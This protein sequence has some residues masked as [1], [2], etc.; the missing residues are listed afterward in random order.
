M[1]LDRDQ[2]ALRFNREMFLLRFAR[3]VK[4]AGED[5]ESVAGFF[6]FAAVRVE[7]P[8][9]EVRFFGRDECKDSITTKSPI[10]IADKCDVF[11]C[12]LERE[13]LRF[14]DNVVVAQAM[15]AEKT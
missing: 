2:A 11:R 9:T 15:A 5:A 6:R 3:R 10:A 8:Q 4:I 14:H 13:H 12:Q 1:Q 7:D